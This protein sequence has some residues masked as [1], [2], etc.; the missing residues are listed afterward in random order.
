MI[1]IIMIIIDHVDK[2]EP[3]G[4]AAQEPGADEKGRAMIDDEF[5]G[6][7]QH[8]GRYHAGQKHHLR[9]A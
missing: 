5:A 3:G 8:R 1:K 4:G 9:D 7:P 6:E 2:M